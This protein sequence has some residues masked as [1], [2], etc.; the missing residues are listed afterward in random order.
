MVKYLACNTKKLSAAT[1]DAETVRYSNAS[2]LKLGNI[3]IQNFASNP[4]IE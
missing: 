4:S 3:Y 1:D 2:L